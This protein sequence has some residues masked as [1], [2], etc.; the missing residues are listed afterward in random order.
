MA[1][2]VLFCTPTQDVSLLNNLHDSDK[3]LSNKEDYGNSDFIDNT[4]HSKAMHLAAALKLV[5]AVFKI[6]GVTLK[7]FV[8]HLKLSNYSMLFWRRLLILGP[9]TFKMMF[10]KAELSGSKDNTITNQEKLF[11]PWMA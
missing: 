5:V 11:G 10:H 6:I 4:S 9:I 7:I 1:E 2:S 8:L 3:E